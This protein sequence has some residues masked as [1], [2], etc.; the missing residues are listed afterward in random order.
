MSGKTERRSLKINE[1][2]YSNM[3]NVNNGTRL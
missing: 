2:D 3:E 1:N